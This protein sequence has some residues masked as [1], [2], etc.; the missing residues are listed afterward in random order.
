MKNK[1]FWPLVIIASLIAAFI[2]NS[3][4]PTAN[5]FGILGTATGIFLMPAILALIIA[6]ILRLFKKKLEDGKFNNMY[7]IIWGCILVFYLLGHFMQ[8]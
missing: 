5:I 7:L 4:N 3:G 6:G 2:L 8:P 1:Y